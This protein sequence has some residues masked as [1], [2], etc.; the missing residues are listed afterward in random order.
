MAKRLLAYDPAV[1]AA[2]N[3]Y[4]IHV[5][6]NADCAVAVEADGTRFF[7]H[8]NGVIRTATRIHRI[9]VPQAALDRAKA[10]TVVVT[11]LLERL[12]YRSRFAPEERYDFAFRPVPPDTIRLYHIADTHG[13]TAPAIR[14]ARQFGAPIDLLVL[15]GDIIDASDRPS[16][17]DA[18]YRLTQE[19]THGGVP[20]ICA[21]GNHDLRG[22]AAERLWEYIPTVNGKTYYT[23]RVGNIWAI[24]LDT[25]EDKP[26]SHEEYNGAVCCEVFRR[27]ETA[28]LR[29]VIANAD[30]EYNAPGVSH[31]LVIAHTPFTYVN[32]PPFDIEQPLFR[33]WAALLREQVR[34]EL[35]LAGHQHCCL[36]SRPGDDFDTLGQPCTVVVGADPD[37][38]RAFTGCGVILTQVAPK[39]G[40]YRG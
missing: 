7:D 23:L 5:R 16:D 30:R 20:V 18:I 34:P 28:F 21:R 3:D 35:F 22:R 38:D 6:V 13:E 14:S 9:R 33:T 27:E 15:N 19:I 26:D 39:I 29:D 1:F 10:Y 17:F 40:F 25:G 2:G 31:R 37:G 32:R 24:V 8:S 12:A 36:V 11:P 4:Q